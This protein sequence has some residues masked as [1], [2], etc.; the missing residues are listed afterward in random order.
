MFFEGIERDQWYKW[1]KSY[2]L[3]VTQRS[4]KY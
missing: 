2:H 3:I 4:K 1:V